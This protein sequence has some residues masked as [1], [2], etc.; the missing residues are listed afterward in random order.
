MKINLI[1]QMQSLAKSATQLAKAG[2]ERMGFNAEDAMLRNKL[3][4]TIKELEDEIDLQFAEIGAL[5][6][7]THT[8]TPAPSSDIQEILSYVDSLFEQV[9]GH[10]RQLQILDG[11][12]FCPACDSA[13]APQNTFCK[14]CGTKLA[15]QLEDADIDD[16][17]VVT[18]K[19]TVEEIIEEVKETACEVKEEVCEAVCGEDNQ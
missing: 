14:D 2:A 10:E 12:Q 8:G 17:T 4:R 15:P 18:I 13:N 11:F 19:E 16:G 1:D 9:E 6:Y 3:Q 7:A 5:I